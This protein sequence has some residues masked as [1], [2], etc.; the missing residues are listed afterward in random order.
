MNSIKV[1]QRKPKSCVKFNDSKGGKDPEHG[2]RDI[3]TQK[4]FNEITQREVCHRPAPILEH[5]DIILYDFNYYSIKRIKSDYAQLWEKV[6]LALTLL[7]EEALSCSFNINEWPYLYWDYRKLK[8]IL[9]EGY[10]GILEKLEYDNIISIEQNRSVINPVR[11]WNCFK[12]NRQF[13]QMDEPYNSTK[14]LIN[15]SYERTILTYF[16]K[17]QKNQTKLE[18]NIVDTLLNTSIEIDNSDMTELLNHLV[19]EKKNKDSFMLENP[20]ES[21][22][23][24]ANIQ[25]NLKDP[26]YYTNY[27]RLIVT[28]IKRINH[29]LEKSSDI[30]KCK[31]GVRKSKYG[32]RISH[33]CS[34][35]PKELRYNLQI[36]GEKI[37]EVD[38]ITSQPS[39]LLSMIDEWFNKSDFAS[40]NNI[41]YPEFF[42]NSYNLIQL[43]SEN[44][45]FYS[46]MIINFNKN[47]GEVDFTRDQMKLLF[48]KVVFGDLDFESIRGFNRIGLITAL[49]GSDFY[50]F[51]LSV[52]RLNVE[53]I[54]KSESYKNLS[55]LLQRKEAALLEEVMNELILKEIK[56]LPLYDSLIVKESD[57]W[58]VIM[59]YYRIIDKNNLNEFIRIK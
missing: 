42:I 45:D 4:Y 23:K 11:T 18:N 28:T 8:A 20:F 43:D 3:E 32:N 12:L 47:V 2:L 46:K 58:Q 10:L 37:T 34:N 44:V 9:G 50:D 57:V 53:G 17:V 25:R 54:D 59:T 1:R 26:N 6:A 15:P 39:F 27:E 48:M 31:L 41:S 29:K 30:S 56:F 7:Y 40:K 52:N 33:F 36:N 14:M 38:I 24:V 16:K 55:A 22:D 51:L 21:G 35:I 13:I 19:N 49:F 5:S